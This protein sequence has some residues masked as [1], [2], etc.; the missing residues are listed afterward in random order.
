ANAEMNT[1]EI[2][3]NA[4]VS[5]AFSIDGENQTAPLEGEDVSALM[6]KEEST[7][8]TFGF[9]ATQLMTVFILRH[10]HFLFI[11]RTYQILEPKWQIFRFPLTASKFANIKEKILLFLKL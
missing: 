2:R 7:V 5:M 10:I 3:S 8:K 9:Q 11:S 6:V 1:I 4:A